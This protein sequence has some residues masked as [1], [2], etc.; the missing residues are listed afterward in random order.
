MKKLL[1][2]TLPRPISF[3]H[4]LDIAFLPSG[5][6][7]LHSPG[8]YVPAPNVISEMKF[9]D[10]GK[11]KFEMFHA[12]IMWQRLM[13]LQNQVR[14]KNRCGRRGCRER[15]QRVC[16][17]EGCRTRY[18]CTE[19]QT[20]YVVLYYSHSALIHSLRC[21]DWEEHRLVCGF[22]V[23]DRPPPGRAIMKVVIPRKQWR[24]DESSSEGEDTSDEDEGLD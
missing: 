7:R 16:A 19:C 12:Q 9:E 1:R 14:V 24:D 8:A 17:K 21:R 11:E 10:L 20:L 13:E 15:A 22:A 4:L 3:R 23:A 6:P 5:L 18:C 2:A